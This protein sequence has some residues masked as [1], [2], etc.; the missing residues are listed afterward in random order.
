MLLRH[1]RRLQ[2]N[3]P[4]PAFVVAA[5]I[6]L[7]MYAVNTYVG[8]A[9]R[10]FAGEAGADGIPSDEINNQQNGALGLPAGGKGGDRLAAGGQR[11]ARAVPQSP[12]E[13]DRDRR[14]VRTGPFVVDLPLS[15]LSCARRCGTDVLVRL[16]LPGPSGNNGAKPCSCDAKSCSS[17]IPTASQCCSDMDQKCGAKA[18]QNALLANTQSAQLSAPLRI[19]GFPPMHSGPEAQVLDVLAVV[20]AEGILAATLSEWLEWLRFAGVGLFHI[21]DC[22][23]AAGAIHALLRPYVAEGYIV[24]TS[25]DGMCGGSD[26]KVS[27]A[28]L[29]VNA[30]DAVTRQRGPKTGGAL[31]RAQLE[32]GELPLWTATNAAAPDAGFVATYLLQQPATMGL[33]ETSGQQQ[34]AAGG[35][36]KTAARYFIRVSHASGLGIYK[37]SSWLETAASSAVGEGGICVSSGGVLQ[38]IVER[39][40]AAS[41]A[42]LNELAESETLFAGIPSVPLRS[43]FANHGQVRSNLPHAA[44]AAAVAA[45]KD[46]APLSATFGGGP[47]ERQEQNMAHPQASDHHIANARV[48]PPPK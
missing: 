20:P 23:S 43:Q 41:F 19:P 34:T 36:M 2:R 13:G 29:Q 38:P 8:V 12:R 47:P 28:T 33:V 24:Y 40:P 15:R 30:W 7:L 16:L 35:E 5:S 48:W 6:V 32:V 39:I 25:W 45:A 11:T 22:G 27:W 10:H 26:T 44:A 31:W 21:Y 42:K 9:N 14:S 1:L 17:T 3:G 18:R 4:H 37:G 46:H